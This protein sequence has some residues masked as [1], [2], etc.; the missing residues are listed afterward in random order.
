[1]PS[2]ATIMPSNSPLLLCD[3]DGT[4]VDSAPDLGDALNRLL[5][6]Q[7]KPELPLKKVISFVGDGARK[8]VERGIKATGLEGSPQSLDRLTERFLE[9]YEQSLTK[10]TRPY[11]GLVEALEQVRD[12]GWRLAVCTNKP[13]KPSR[14]ILQDLNLSAFFETV[15]GGD[16]YDVRKPDPGHILRLIEDLDASPAETIMLGDG[17]NDVRAAAAAGI[18]VILAGFGYGKP[19]LGHPDED[20]EPDLTIE[21]YSELFN[22]LLQLRGQKRA[23]GSNRPV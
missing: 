12:A 22:G 6:E 17:A 5:K 3:L 16:S 14:R 7:G 23:A 20:L 18:P 11:P 15:A 4:L 1:M 9:L 19:P 10:E 2:H 8:L 21:S 13:E